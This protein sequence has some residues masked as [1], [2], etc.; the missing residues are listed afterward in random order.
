LLNTGLNEVDGGGTVRSCASGALTTIGDGSYCVD[1]AATQLI[2][3]DRDTNSNYGV[4]YVYPMGVFA[5]H[6]YNLASDAVQGAYSITL[7]AS[8]SDV[9]VGDIVAIDENTDNDPNVYWG[10]NHDPAGGGSRR[11]FTFMNRQDRSLAQIVEVSAVDGATI[12]F[13]TPLTYP[14]HTAYSAQLTTA[15]GP[16]LHG[17]GI[18]NLF[19]WGGVG[20]D[21]NGN[22]PVTDCAYCWVK[23]VESSWAV[24]SNV[25]FYQTFRNVLRDSY[26][27]E[28]PNPTPGGAGYL[29]TMTGGASENLV[30]NNIF[31]YGDKVNTM[32][33]TGGGNVFAYN[34]TD[35]AFGDQFPDSPEAGINAG[36]YTTPHLELLE[37]NYSHNFKGDT[38]WGNSIYI[39]AFRNWLTAHRASHAPLNTYSYNDGSC[40]H[41]Y[42]DYNGPAR[43]AVDVQG[44]SF[45]QNFVGNV[46]GMSGQQ[47]LGASGCYGAQTGWLLQVTTTAQWN[48]E[49]A[50]N[51]VP[52]WQL[53][54]L[55][56]STGWAFVDAT[57]N[58]Q[59]RTANWDWYTR[60]MHCYG[61]GGTTDLGCSGV[62]IPNSFYLAA[63][64]A[65]FGTNPWPWV[66]PTTGTTYTLPAKYCFEHGEMPTCLQ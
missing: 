41:N 26:I 24:G 59:T 38:F 49:N 62:T 35:D 51:P 46:L 12:T 27:H 3:V 63:K 57:I 16:F 44:D 33:A 39:T 7:T 42:G 55:Q 5:N 8:P 34:Y 9:H 50:S 23:N 61:T 36:H 60:A 56:A 45:Y 66:D 47:L 30:E 58:T 19:V 6:S 48:A 10:T 65:F 53:G 22:I 18:E 17:A 1:S 54:I 32:R 13:D 52:M 14:F 43:A 21:G 15:T 25:G 31:W 37:G 40:T 11:W 64:P 4:L 28:T 29:H 20:G 2:K